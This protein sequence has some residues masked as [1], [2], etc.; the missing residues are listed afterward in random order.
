MTSPF[1]EGGG[2]L[3]SWERERE[4]DVQDFRIFRVRRISARSPRTG[5]PHP[6]TVLECP[7]WVNV[8]ALTK[9]RNLVL[10]RQFRHGT[11]RVT[12][13]IPGG[14]VE[15]G[16]APADA[17]ERELRE[18]TGYVGGEPI[19]LGVVEPNPAIQ[20]NHCHLFLIEGCS[21]LAER[22]LDEGE[23]IEVFTAPVE[24]AY[25]AVRGGRIRHALVICALARLEER[26]V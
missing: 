24:E 9:E 20:T 23:D 11:G 18:E 7:D 15:P 4:D 21:L 16:E 22:D 12:L 25:A 26:G 19:L 6:F 5:R 14:V 17:A 8:V 10:I 13:E 1:D 2:A 3:G